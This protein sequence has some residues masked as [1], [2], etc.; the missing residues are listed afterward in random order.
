MIPA[1]KEAG[2]A[3]RVRIVLKFLQIQFLKTGPL[4]ER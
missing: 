1:L 4:R 3:S 2:M